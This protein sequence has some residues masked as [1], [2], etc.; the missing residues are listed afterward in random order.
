MK[1]LLLAVLA[2]A[3]LSGCASEGLKKEAASFNFGTAP[4]S[5][6]V[7]A[8]VPAFFNNVLID[9]FSA[10]YQYSAPYKAWLKAGLIQGGGVAWEGWAVDVAVNAKNRMGGYTGWQP[11]HVA[12][13]NGV[14]VNA[15]PVQAVD[16]LWYRVQ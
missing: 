5:D 3:M 12:F 8:S 10:H 1:I 13:S 2:A 9:P 16:V 6:Q 15:Y 11:Y 4:A 14:P 7:A